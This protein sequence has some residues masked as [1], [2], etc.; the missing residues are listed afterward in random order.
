MTSPYRNPWKGSPWQE[1]RRAPKSAP[2]NKAAARK[3]MALA[4]AVSSS[5]I[6]AMLLMAFATIR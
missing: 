2:D 6:I 1:R 5:G 4:M 3:R